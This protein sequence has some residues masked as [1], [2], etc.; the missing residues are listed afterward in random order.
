MVDLPQPDL[1]D[2]AQRLALADLEAHVVDRLDLA[3]LAPE[4]AG[5]DREVHLQADDPKQRR[6]LR[7]H[8]AAP[9]VAGSHQHATSCPMPTGMRGG[10]SMRHRSKTWPHRGAN[11]QKSGSEVSTGGC[12]SM[13]RSRR[14]RGPAT[15]GTVPSSARV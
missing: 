9:L 10:F 4:Q 1:A 6:G 11:G 5:M 3:D 15:L 13:V 12:P 7:R 14:A 2:E 8:G